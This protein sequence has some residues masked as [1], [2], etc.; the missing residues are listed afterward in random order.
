MTVPASPRPSA[1][2]CLLRDGDDGME[3]M[4]GRR[5]A[6]ARFMANAWVFP[7]GRVDEADRERAERLVQG[8][9]APSQ[10]PWILAA[11]RETVE[12]AGVWLTDPP[13]SEALGDRDVYEALEAAGE[14]FVADVHYFANWVTP[15]DLPIRYDA[16]FFATVLTADICPVPDNEEIVEIKWVRPRDVILRA[17]E[18]AWIVPFPTHVTLEQLAGA[19]STAAFMEHAAAID[20]ETV[21]PRIKMEHDGSIRLVLPGE[22][23]YDELADLRYDFSEL[24]AAA[25]RLQGPGRRRIAELE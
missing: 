1:T 4:M 23:D 8:D 22:P 14:T 16:R 6:T 3:V 5:S 18:G 12:E 13:R 21:Q 25:R 11:L 17:A 20:V 24:A 2:I 19:T 15:A 9:N 10:R 7:G